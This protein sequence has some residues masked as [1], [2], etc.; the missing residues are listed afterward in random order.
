MPNKIIIMKVIY[1][2]KNRIRLSYLFCLCVCIVLNSCGE[3][4][5]SQED[6][7]DYFVE[8][9]DYPESEKSKKIL[10]EYKENIKNYSIEVMTTFGANESD[11]EDDWKENANAK[12]DLYGQQ[13][14]LEVCQ[15]KR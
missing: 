1:V 9:R 6:A 5:I 11:M 13:Y 12:L 4:K 7:C 2:L 8:L 15:S 3:K 14:F 10:I